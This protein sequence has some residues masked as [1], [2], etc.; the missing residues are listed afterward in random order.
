MSK[1]FFDGLN[2]KLS[3]EPSKDFDKKFW[4]EFNGEFNKKPRKLSLFAKLVPVSALAILLVV[5]GVNLT[6]P[7]ANQT[8]KIKNPELLQ[9]L[10]LLMHIDDEVFDLA[11]EDW[12]ALMEEEKS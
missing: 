4:A 12:E 11:Q 1:D 8:A 9:N 6:G 3:H 10:D 7:G 2:S 5:I